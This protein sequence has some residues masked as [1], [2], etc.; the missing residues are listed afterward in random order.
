M[1]IIMKK[2]NEILS[3]WSK[4]DLYS[5]F[6][7]NIRSIIENIFSNIPDDAKI[8]I[9]GAG[10]HTRQLLL[11]F[12][13]GRKNILAIADRSINTSEKYGYKLI[14]PD[15]ISKYD[16]DYV[17]ISSFLFRKEMASELSDISIKTIDPYDVLE[18]NNIFLNS[19][20]FM[21][22]DGWFHI[23]HLTV[24]YF[25]L[26]Y[27]KNKDSK[28]SLSLLKEAINVAFG[29]KDLVMYKKLC[30]IG[31]EKF[32]GVDGE[33][34]YQGNKLL[35]EF[36]S[37]LKDRIAARKQNDIFLF[38][39]D[40]VKFSDLSHLKKTYELSKK[41]VFFENPYSCAP[42]THSTLDYIFLD[43]MPIDD[44]EK[45][46]HIAD[47]SSSNLIR[48]LH[49]NGYDFQYFGSSAKNVSREYVC[50]SSRFESAN[51]VFWNA[52]M[53][54]INCSEPVFYM[55]HFLAE[56]HEMISPVCENIN[57][58][59]YDTDIRSQQFIAH[60]YMDDCL[61]LYRELLGDNTYIYMSD[62]GD[63][64]DNY[65]HFWDDIRI[66]PYCFFIQ[67]GVNPN[68]VK[69]FFPYKNIYL[70][71]D[72]LIHHNNNLEDML[73]DHMVY[74]DIDVYN[75]DLINRFI[76]ERFSMIFS[77]RAARDLYYKY[78]INSV[79]EEFFC[80]YDEN[81]RELPV[82]SI[83]N[84]ELSVLKELA[85]TKFIDVY[86]FPKFEYTRKAYDIYQK[87]V[88]WKI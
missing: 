88:P 43:R 25:F 85:G 60:Q 7:K 36:K 46:L 30:D 11:E 5:E 8:I 55:L 49:S 45:E 83:P 57:T 26:R 13:L 81:G 47:S 31:E 32:S 87:S 66:K 27:L 22:C 3:F 76:K 12:D 56:T 6:Q 40:A 73:Q 62:H 63:A 51:I 86:Q 74:Q 70:L 37:L 61:E 42:F 68:K 23:S 15:D 35:E 24:N 48:V 21:Y 52:V 2:Y 77:Y 44:F 1:E 75:P 19:P 34:F 79:G 82:D 58:D 14:S 29:A 64:V 18:K 53:R 54:L 33:V 84:D 65:D 59:I 4:G 50:L 41:G 72:H 28:I 69:R 80:R 20:L 39:T 78:A 16:P 17:I 10:E 67:K 9:R 71:A 38:W